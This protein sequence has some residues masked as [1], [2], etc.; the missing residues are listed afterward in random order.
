[1]IEGLMG[2]TFRDRHHMRAME[3]LGHGVIGGYWLPPSNVEGEVSTPQRV[4]HCDRKDKTAKI[5]AAN[6]QTT[7]F[8]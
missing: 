7:Y 8:D 2:D 1:M 6:K 4:Q 5:K 3:F